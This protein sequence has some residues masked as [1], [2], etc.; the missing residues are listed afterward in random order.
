MK[1]LV[2][3]LICILFVEPCLNA[4]KIDY[5][6]IASFPQVAEKPY[7]PLSES[8]ALRVKA[9][10]F[11]AWSREHH[12]PYYGG[13]M[14]EV[15][16]KDE[17][18]EEPTSYGGMGDSCIWTGV[19]LASQSLRYAVTNDPIAKQNIIRTVHA[20]HH[21]LKVTGKKGFIARYWYNL[22]SKH[23]DI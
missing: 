4:S 2:L 7:F 3:I 22:P 13:Y 9:E 5:T 17:T 19:Y 16:F 8:G 6:D 15:S 23:S 10:G 20:L 18:Y 21:F 12:A 14:T 11:D 1:I